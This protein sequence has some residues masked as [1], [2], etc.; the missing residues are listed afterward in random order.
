MINK[1]ICIIIFILILTHSLLTEV[2]S[3]VSMLYQCQ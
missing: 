3:Q 2:V 1:F